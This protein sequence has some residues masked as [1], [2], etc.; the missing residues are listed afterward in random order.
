MNGWP[1]IRDAA[2]KA[3]GNLQTR[4]AERARFSARTLVLPNQ[5]DGSVQQFYHFLLGYLMPLCM[6]LDHHGDTKIALRD[7]GPMNTWIELLQEDL[8]IQVMQP[9][10]ALHMVVGKRMKLKV[11]KGMDY[12]S[13]FDRSNLR[14]G[15]AALRKWLKLEVRNR[16]AESVQIV[17]IDRASSESFYQSPGSETHMSGADRRTVPNIA[18]VQYRIAQPAVARVVDLARIPPRQQVEIVQDA[19]VLVGQHGAGL[20][21][22]LWMKQGSVVIEISPP[23]PPEVK[24]LFATMADALGHSYFQVEQ[25]DV[26]SSISLKEIAR[27]INLHSSKKKV[28]Y[29][30]PRNESNE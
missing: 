23:L 1:G 14:R 27:L 15:E 11:L 8:D 17:I 19:D 3:I 6:W 20:A 18:E 22:M 5:W 4:K 9:G 25:N 26:K 2:N 28:E 10:M 13:Q 30:H 12:P 24:D 29:G 7:C 21:H 16:T